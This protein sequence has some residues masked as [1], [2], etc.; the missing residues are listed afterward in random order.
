MKKIFCTVL[1][2]II[3]LSFVGCRGTNKDSAEKDNI[4]SISGIKDKDKSESTDKLSASN[5]KDKEKPE[6]DTTP[7]TENSDDGN[8]AEEVITPPAPTPEPEAEPE[9][10]VTPPAP[11]PAPAPTPEVETPS[12]QPDTTERVFKIVTMNSDCQVVDGGEV[13]TIGLGVAENIREILATVSNNYFGGLGIELSTIET[14]NGNRIAVINLTGDES[15]W[16]QKMQGSTG[17]QM[18]QYTLIENVLQ[19]NYTG[20]WIHGVRFTLN[21]QQLQNNDHTPGLS[22]TTYR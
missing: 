2:C 5:E 20:Y 10:A 8:K 21:G 15:L 3:S 4:P 14:I 9:V 19:R 22:E 18:T 13:R 16:H 7:S 12:S 11:T 17:G 6:E 1:I